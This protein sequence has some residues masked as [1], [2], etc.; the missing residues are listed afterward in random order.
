MLAINPQELADK[1]WS[2]N[3]NIKFADPN[4][5]EDPELDSQFYI[6]EKNPL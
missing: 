4:K 2:S 3:D 6:T 5:F 1:N